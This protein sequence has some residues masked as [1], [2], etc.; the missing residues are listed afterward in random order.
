M[1]KEEEKVKFQIQPHNFQSSPDAT[2]NRSIWN[3]CTYIWLFL[4]LLFIA[5]TVFS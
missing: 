4:I 5:E 2:C 3:T 1:L